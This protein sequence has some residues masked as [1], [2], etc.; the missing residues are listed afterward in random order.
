MANTPGGH[1]PLDP[2]AADRLLELLSTDD[3]FRELFVRDRENAL[4]QVGYS[5][6]N[7]ASIQCNAVSDI[8]SKKV[9]AAARE[10]LKEYLT[11]SA[12]LTNP[13]CFEAGRINEILRRK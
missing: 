3:D 11:S 9:I 5:E 7:N 6:P 1:P 4:K 8:A 2:A 10:E 13:H 12:A